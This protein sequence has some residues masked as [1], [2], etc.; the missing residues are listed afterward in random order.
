MKKN[1][2][3]FRL[4]PGTLVLVKP[5]LDKKYSKLAHRVMCLGPIIVKDKIPFA[6]CFYS[7]RNHAERYIN[8]PLGY[9]W[10]VNYH[11]DAEL[12]KLYSKWYKKNN[13]EY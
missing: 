4:Q 11:D 9:L 7:T 12:L 6:K 1:K 2:L 8:I 13:L 3:P 5:N 10:Y